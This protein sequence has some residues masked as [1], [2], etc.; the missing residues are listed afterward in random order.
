[1]DPLTR[2]RFH[3]TQVPTIALGIFLGCFWALVGTLAVVGSGAVWWRV[4]AS[5]APGAAVL[6]LTSLAR[7]APVPYGAGLIAL[8]LLP[9]LAVWVRAPLPLKLAFGLPVVAVGV[10]FILWRRR[11]AE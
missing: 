7:R 1:V 10:G 9:L 8:G 3:W 11:L 5:A 4:A 6:L 2:P